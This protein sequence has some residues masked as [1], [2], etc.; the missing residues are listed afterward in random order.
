MSMN[1]ISNEPPQKKPYLLCPFY[2]RT[3]FQKDDHFF[4]SKSN[5]CVFQVL[6][7]QVQMLCFKKLFLIFATNQSLHFVPYVCPLQTPRALFSNG[8]SV[9]WL[10][11]GWYYASGGGSRALLSFL[12]LVSLRAHLKQCLPH[13]RTP[14][15]SHESEYSSTEQRQRLDGVSVLMRTR[16]P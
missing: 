4:S 12:S 8:T 10:S 7:C 13:S 2:T 5:Y 15:S 6:Q 1:L 14:L 3:H 16:S 9:L 11:V